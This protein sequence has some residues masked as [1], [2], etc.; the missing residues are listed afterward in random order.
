MRINANDFF[1]KNMQQVAQDKAHNLNPNTKSEKRL[2]GFDE[3]QAEKV[4]K[5]FETMFVDMMLKSMRQTARPDGETNAQSVYSSMLD[6]EYGKAMTDSTNFGI[7]DLILNWMQETS[8][9]NTKKESS[10]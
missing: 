1:F 6:T 2:K 8:G 10:K 3:A 5:D 7:R 4:A 9:Q